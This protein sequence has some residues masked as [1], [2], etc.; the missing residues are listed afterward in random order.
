MTINGLTQ[1]PKSIRSFPGGQKWKEA[2][3]QEQAKKKKERNGNGEV[4]PKAL[5][6]T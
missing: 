3:N 1:K 6:E 2:N 4:V 5:K